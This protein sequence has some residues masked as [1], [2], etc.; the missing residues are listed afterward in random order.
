VHDYEPSWD[1]PVVELGQVNIEGE[2]RDAYERVMREVHAT[3]L[4]AL[5]ISAIEVFHVEACGLTTAHSEHACF[6][7]YCSGTSSRPVIGLDLAMLSECC[8]ENDCDF[9]YELRVTLAHELAHAHQETLGVEFIADD[10]HDELEAA[11]EEFG[12]EWAMGGGV[13][14]EMLT[15]MTLTRMTP[16]WSDAVEDSG[17]VAPTC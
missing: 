17:C 6:A 12:R 1:Y 9:T 16:A 15:C 13:N 4:P 7:L 2:Q 3:L 10:D 8:D 14:I 5:G 11:A